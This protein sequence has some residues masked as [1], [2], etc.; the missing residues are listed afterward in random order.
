[1][2]NE[3]YYPSSDKKTSI[4]AIEW[5]PDG[6]VAGILQIAH[7]MVEY[8]DRYDCFAKY[9][10]ERGFIVVG[11]DYLGHGK[12]VTDVRELGYIGKG[13]GNGLLIQDIR[14]LYKLTRDKY[15]DIP[16][17]MLGHSMGSFIMR[18]YIGTFGDELS[19]AIIMGTGYNPKTVLMFGEAFT[20]IISMVKGGHYRS[21]FVNNLGIGSYNKQ[22][23]N[24]QTAYDWVTTDVEERTKYS[25]D[26]FCTFMFTVNGYNSLFKGMYRM[27]LKKG[28]EGTPKD[29]S[30]LF[31]SGSEDAVGEFEKGVNKV[32]SIYEKMGIKDLTKIF[33]EGERH[34][35]LNGVSR[36]QVFEDI[37]NWLH[38][39]SNTKWRNKMMN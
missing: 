18:Q 21:A 15:K 2:K 39:R 20:K 30:V 35:I 26:P 14:Q 17:F 37:Y 13:D 38:E 11:N 16:Y 9:L 8:I 6:E 28:Y 19:G 27:S 7:G 10:C 36:S 31:T 22:F 5:V 34:E 12:S 24:T 33:Y 25:K 23:K 29:L 32:Y 3:F 1:M 4:H